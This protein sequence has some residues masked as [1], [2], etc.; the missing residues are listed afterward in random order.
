MDIDY[1]D[2]QQFSPEFLKTKLFEWSFVAF[3]SLSVSG[4]GVFLIIPIAEPHRH[5]HHF[6]ALQKDFEAIGVKVD[7]SPKNI[8][9]LRGY[10]YDPNRLIRHRPQTYPKTLEAGEKKNKIFQFEPND[11]GD[12]TKR[13][14]ETLIEK[15]ISTR[16]DITSHEPDWFR[17]ACALVN[18][19]GEEG[20]RYFH[21]LSQFYPKYAE[22]ETDRKYNSALRGRYHKIGIGTLFK[23]AKDYGVW[24]Y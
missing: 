15:I 12:Q 6:L 18:T 9:S 8:A 17:I 22:K 2:N 24:L 1:K 3:A 10:S 13:K 20:R 4:Q 21:A 11:Q 23:I 19:F 5:P 16:I 7:Q 14:V